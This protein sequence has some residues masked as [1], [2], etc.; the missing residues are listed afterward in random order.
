M[1][2]CCYLTVLRCLACVIIWYSVKGHEKYFFYTYSS[3]IL[4]VFKKLCLNNVHFLSVRVDGSKASFFFKP[5]FVSW[6]LCMCPDL[7][8]ANASWI[9]MHLLI[10][11]QCVKICDSCCTSSF[12]H[13]QRVHSEGF[14]F[15]FFSYLIWKFCLRRLWNAQ[16]YLALVGWSSLPPV[17]SHQDFTS[18]FFFCR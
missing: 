6:L 15:C 1:L 8:F 12:A 2:F 11:V 17:L 4:K 18:R 3:L 9:W 13:S 14:I 10:Y 16:V 5:S 7:F